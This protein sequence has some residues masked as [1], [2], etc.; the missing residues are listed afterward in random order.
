M[1]GSIHLTLLIGP[2]A[3]VPAP[4]EVLEALDAVQVTSSTGSSGFQLTFKVGK[5][6]I[7]QTVLLPAGYF[8]PIITRVIIVATVN[9]LPNVLM[10]GVIT[11]QEVSPNNE[12]GKS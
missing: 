7:L 5:D 8:D 2:G 6:S 10:D 4:P 1:A 12:V 11:R 3:P 9:G